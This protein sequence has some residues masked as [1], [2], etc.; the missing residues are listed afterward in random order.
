MAALSKKAQYLQRKAELELERA[1]WLDLW[2]DLNDQFCPRLGRFLASEQNK[3]AKLNEKIVNSSPLNAVRILASGMM[4]GCSSPSRTWFRLTTPDPELA[5]QDAAKV[6]LHWVEERMRKAMA[7]SDL[8]LALARGYEEEGV[9]GTGLLWIEPAKTGDK[10]LHAETIPIG[11]YCLACGEDGQ[12]DTLYRAFRMTVRQLAQKFGLEACSASVRREY[13]EKHFDTWHD[14]CHV[15]EPRSLR[16]EASPLARDMP[17]ASTWFEVASDEDQLL[18][19]SGYE[20]KPFAASRWYLTAGDVYGRSPAMDCLGDAKALQKLESRKLLALEKYV[21]PPMVGPSSLREDRASLLPGDI[22]YVDTVSGGQTFQ[23]AIRIDPGALSEIGKEILRHEQ[24]IDDAMLVSIFMMLSQTDRRQ[25]TATEI[26]ERKE[27]KSLQ[28]GPALERLHYEK[29][30]PMIARVFGIMNRAGL[31]P[32]PP[33][34]LQGTELKIEFVSVLAAA[35]KLTG[36]VSIERFS[37]YMGNLAAALPEVIDVLEPDK[38][39]REYAAAVGLNPEL[40]RAEEEVLAMRKQRTEQAQ[41]AQQAQLAAQGAQ[42]AQTVAQ[43]AQ[44]LSQTDIRGDSAL[45]RLISASGAGLAPG[46]GQA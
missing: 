9:F 44:T 10:L 13:E 17:W 25:I 20:E 4:A 29:F 3:G 23:P 33:P 41:Q 6:W 22:T 11:Q 32:P 12:V 19:E 40:L 24:R 37:S 46:V 14:V 27:E 21:N 5:E 35:Q 36:V 42:T 2:R 31:I 34:E 43:G 45:S 7:S 18:L 26:E 8:Y 16:D 15:V 39:A 28:I 38:A 30:G 1:S